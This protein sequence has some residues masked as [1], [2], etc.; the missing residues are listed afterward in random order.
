MVDPAGGPYLFDNSAESWLALSQDAGVLGAGY[1]TSKLRRDEVEST[2][3][4][5]FEVT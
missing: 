2:Y 1:L 5:S 4:L 3:E